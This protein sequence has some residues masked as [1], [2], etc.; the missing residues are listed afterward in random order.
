MSEFTLTARQIRQMDRTIVDR[1]PSDLPWLHVNH[2]DC[3]IEHEKALTEISLIRATKARAEIEGDAETLKQLTP[4]LSARALEM[5][6]TSK[7]GPKCR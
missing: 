2:P 4:F 1:G 7:G 6:H 5:T 3:T